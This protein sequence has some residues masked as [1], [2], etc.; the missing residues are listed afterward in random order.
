MKTETDPY[1]EERPWGRYRVV[2][3]G[4]GFKIKVIEVDP[5]MRLSYQSHKHREERW[6]IMDGS[7]LVTID[8]NKERHLRGDTV[9][10]DREGKHRV[11]NAGEGVLRFVEVQLGEYLGEDDI[12]RYEDDFG[13][14]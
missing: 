1:W 4:S 11:E 8:G 9:R 6:V 13:R 2:T 5:G 3:E 14:S 10:I 12:E 7:A